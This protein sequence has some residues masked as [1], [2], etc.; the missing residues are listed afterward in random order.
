[1][2]ISLHCLTCQIS[3][4]GDDDVHFSQESDT[5]H[6]PFEFVAGDLSLDFI[7]TL[8]DRPTEH[9]IERLVTYADLVM[10][11]EQGQAITSNLAH[12]LL[13]LAKR[14]PHE[15]ENHLADAIALR[16]ALNAIYDAVVAGRSAPAS[17]LA[18]LN[19]FLQ[20]A[21]RNTELKSHH[22]AFHWEWRHPE[23]SLQSVLWPIVRAAAELLSSEDLGF[24]R[25]CAASTCDWFFVD[26]TKNHRRRWCDMK[27]CGNRDKARR[28]YQR[29]RAP[30]KR[31]RAKKPGA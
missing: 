8:G 11:E 14:T 9:P 22:G 15:A 4:S 24:V 5:S 21:A 18:L 17:E 25:H 13:R 26:R 1:M 12:A 3:F 7:N 31:L 27:V 6:S 10:W 20:D 23:S 30:Q 19:R 29:T 16:E 2:V 28:H